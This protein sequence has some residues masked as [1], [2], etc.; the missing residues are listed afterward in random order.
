MVTIIL[1]GACGRMGRVIAQMAADD[2]DTK[3]V[4]GVDAFGDKYSDFPIYRSLEEVYEKG[5]V[6]IDFSNAK[7]ADCLIDY[8]VKV[9]VVRL[10]TNFKWD[11]PVG[12][13]SSSSRWSPVR[14][15]IQI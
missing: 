9:R 14:L 11:T 1:H 3:I 12:N 15:T 7:A 8:S 13:R 2:A 10:I 4:A 5:D 6:I